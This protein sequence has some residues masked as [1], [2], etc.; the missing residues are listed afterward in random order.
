MFD[1]KSVEIENVLL[2]LLLQVGLIIAA[3]RILGAVARRLGQPEVIG[4]IV[5]GLLL[6][7]SLFGWLAPQAQA[8][9]FDPTGV[10]GVPQGLMPVIIKI[11]SQLGLILLLFVIGLEFDFSHLV[12]SGPATA[13]ISLA[14]IVLPMGLGAALAYWLY[15]RLVGER[16]DGPSFGNFQL[17]LAVSM[18]ITALP[19]L[20][21]LL[22]EWGAARTRVAT[23]AISSAA[24]DDAMGWILLATIAAFVRAGQASEAWTT[25]VVMAI[26]TLGLLALLVIVVRPLA[27]RWV[28]SSLD[29]HGGEVSL[30]LLS[31]V[32][33]FAFAC[34][35]LTSL[36]GIFAIFGAF[37]A[38][39]ILSGET[40]LATGIQSRMR[41][42]V[43]AFFLPVFFAYTGT[44]TRIGSLAGMET[45]MMA[46]MVL[47]CAVAGKFIGCGLAARLSGF[48]WREAGCIGV[49]M[50]TRALMELIVINVGKDLGVVPDELFTM[51]V[52][53]ALAT[54]VM[55]TPAILWLARGTD[56]EAP[57]RSTGWITS[58]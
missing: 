24:M 46:L 16:G 40:R 15:P 44:R 14:G 20:G 35:V 37:L 57:L 52:L 17:F 6:G 28:R 43:T 29:A 49:L 21:R 10:H 33:V 5:A 23:I 50:N 2:L 12:P 58:R 53:M 38:G 36:I 1:P 41:H 9:L 25:G 42:F 8:A 47:A 55:T 13:A 39:A 19:I 30:M 27:L 56:F 7:P 22:V 54:T 32:L 3:A 51:L 26:E 18:A 4:E 48:G 11:I 34:A 45:A 31:G